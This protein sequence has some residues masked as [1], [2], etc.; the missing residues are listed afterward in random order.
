MPAVTRL[1]R[2]VILLDHGQV[3]A[4]GPAEEVVAHYMSAALGASGSRE[5][6][7]DRAPGENGFRLRAVRVLDAGGNP[8]SSLNIVR[9]FRI[10]LSY[11]TLFSNMRFRCAISLYTQGACAFVTPERQ[12]RVHEK[13]GAYR[14]LVE[15]PGNMLAEGEYI[16]GVSVFASRGK[17]LHYCRVSDTVAFQVTDPLD[18]R[19]A[20]GD[21]AEG[22]GGVMRPLLAWET[23]YDDEGGKDR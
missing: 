9:P 14:A 2:R 17:K 21:Y 20:R 8:A 5:W 10:E 13:A 1:C 18:G 12:E 6:P 11:Q 4:Q 3:S 16:V 23:K 7:A 15:V 19:S 22:L